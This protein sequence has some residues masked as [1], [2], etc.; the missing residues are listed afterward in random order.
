MWIADFVIHTPAKYLEVVSKSQISFKGKAQTE[1]ESAAY[2]GRW[3]IYRRSATQPFGL[4]WG[5]ETC[6]NL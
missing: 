2:I 6:S 5:L 3:G 1:R 4:K